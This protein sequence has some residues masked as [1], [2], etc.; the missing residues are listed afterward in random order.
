MEKINIMTSLEKVKERFKN[1]KEVRCP[2]D[3]NIFNLNAKGVF[4]EDEGNVYFKFDKFQYGVSDVYLYYEGEFAEIISYNKDNSEP[5]KS[6]YPK[7]MLVSMSLEAD[8]KKRVVFMK[9]GGR[10]IAWSY[11]SSIKEA[12]KTFNIT[13]W[14]YAKELPKEIEVTKEEIAKWKGCDVEQLIIK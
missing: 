5:E 11:A 2:Y 9:K 8:W 7:V 4:K 1:A 3:D 6:E 10:F 14:K 13:T 12:E